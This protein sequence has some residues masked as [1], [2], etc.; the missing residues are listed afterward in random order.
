MKSI[1]YPFDGN[2][3]PK[4]KELIILWTVPDEV[5]KILDTFDSQEFMQ[6]LRVDFP[7]HPKFFQTT[8]YPL[9]FHIIAV[10]FWDLTWKKILEVGGSTVFGAFNIDYLRRKWSHALGIDK[11]HDSSDGRLIRCELRDIPKMEQTWDCIFHHRL[12]PCERDHELVIDSKLNSGGYYIAFRSRE[13]LNSA[14][15]NQAVLIG[16]GYKDLSFSFEF[17]STLAM[18]NPDW[19]HVTIL[20]K[21][22]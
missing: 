7:D 1:K 22:L 10:F 12:G 17:P 19:Y 6:S 16:L 20:S 2:S 13:S 14:P 11:A 9:L 18:Q 15:I 21:P 4:W 5:Q 3:S 8:W